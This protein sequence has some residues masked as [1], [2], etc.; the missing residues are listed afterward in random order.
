MMPDPRERSVRRRARRIRWR[1]PPTSSV[2]LSALIVNYDSGGFALACVESLQQEWS[3]DGR[4]S[5]DLEIVV[6]DNASPSDQSDWLARIAERG[7]R[8][9]HSDVN[10][11]YAA[12][13]ALALSHTSGNARDVVAVLNADVEFRPG[14]LRPL[15]ERLQTDPGCGG[16]APRAFVDEGL[17]LQLPRVPAPTPLEHLF[18]A[19]ADRWPLVGR[20]YAARRHR[21]AMVWWS[22]KQP[23]ETDMLAGACFFLRR[24][25]IE[26][27]GGLLDARFPLY[28]EDADLCLR[29][30]SAGYRLVHEPRA[31]ILHRWSRSAGA[32]D[33]FVTEPMRRY[34]LSR[35]AFVAKHHGRVGR[36]VERLALRLV[37]N[38]PAGKRARPIERIV[39]LGRTGVPPVLELGR[40]TRW[41]VEI[42]LSPT[43]IL[44]AGAI[45]EGHV[46]RLDDAAWSWLFA[47]RYWVRALDRDSRRTIGAWTFE[48]TTPARALDEADAVHASRAA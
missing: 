5:G 15:L 37:E 9:V 17:Q 21:R 16:V 48:K 42:G 20:V 46:F 3:R 14:S 41:V 22:A 19:A 32:G 4:E 1:R 35:A 45:G 31:T 11:G 2:R 6:V 39:D 12:G 36:A 30:R 34:W 38:A 44:A 26:R 28:F 7:A 8:V 29:L 40:R 47:G 10:G 24:K 25:A 33:R 18:A 27:A 13:I 23:I 43:W